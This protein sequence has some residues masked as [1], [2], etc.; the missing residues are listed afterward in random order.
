MRRIKYLFWFIIAAV[1]LTFIYQ[2]REFFT[3]QRDI[4]IDLHFVKY[5]TPQLP[6]GLYYLVVFFIGMAVSYFISLSKRF[7]NRK[8][9]RNLKDQIATDERRIGELESR[10]TEMTPAVV[11]ETSPPPPAETTDASNS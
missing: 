5:T 2:N 11:A 7:Q 10:L 3:V 9:I 1:L 4:G 6:T 8:T